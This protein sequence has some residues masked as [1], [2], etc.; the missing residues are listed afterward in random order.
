MGLPQSTEI[1]LSPPPKEMRLRWCDHCRKELAL[2]PEK[3]FE[4]VRVCLAAAIA[5]LKA[6]GR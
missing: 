6:G 2:S 5:R 3:Y 1:L 4:H